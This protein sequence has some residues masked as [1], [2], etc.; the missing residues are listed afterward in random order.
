MNTKLLMMI[1]WF[2]LVNSDQDKNFEKMM[3]AGI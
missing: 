3:V 1:I 2:Y